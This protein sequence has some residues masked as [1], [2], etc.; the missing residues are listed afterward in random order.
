MLYPLRFQPTYRRYIW[1]GQ[2]LRTLLNK[3]IGPGNDYAE[4]WEIVDRESD[5]SIVS[6]GPLTGQSLHAL[7]EQF[8]PQLL[9][10]TWSTRIRSDAVPRNLRGRFPLLLKFLDARLP[11]SVQVHPN[12]AMAANQS[13]PDLGK[14]EAWFVM[15]SGRQSR[16]YAGLNRGVDRR[17]LAQAVANGSPEP[18]LH[19]FAPEAGDCVF[20]PA[21][22]VHAIGGDLLVCEIQQASDTTFR[23][24]DWDRV[25][26]SG[27]PR[28]LHVEQAL[29]AIDFSRGPVD[30]IRWHVAITDHAE[31]VVN[32]DK[33]WL[34]RMWLLTSNRIGGDGQ[35]RILVVVKGEI[36]MHY[37]TT[38]EPLKLG[39]CVLLPAAAPACTL[40]PKVP[41]AILEIRLPEA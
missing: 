3:P 41:S 4:S 17:Q 5:Q 27:K 12:D 19:S 20:I 29:N 9:G 31:P 14:T 35:M 36:D 11:L 40:V 18:I 25:D 38:E 7:V 10:Q 23:L 26:D 2:R 16:I 28:P 13:P 39:Q 6:N 32:C 21:G 22:T 34:S 1:G 8:G 33:F 30:P 37:D 15:A 24:Y